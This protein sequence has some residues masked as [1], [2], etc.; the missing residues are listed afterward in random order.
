MTHTRENYDNQVKELIEKSGKL[1]KIKAEAEF[2]LLYRAALGEETEN[3]N[4]LVENIVKT[5][6]MPAYG[7]EPLIPWNFFNTAVGEV[8]AA[9][10][11]GTEKILF[12]TEIAELTGYSTP[13]IFKELKN[14]NLEGQK[15]GGTWVVN[16]SSVYKYIEKKGKSLKKGGI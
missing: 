14:G 4:E 5:L 6:F 9:V 2:D 8:I 15:R 3:K 13:Y 1:I 7:N 10:K 11:F 12:I 16:E